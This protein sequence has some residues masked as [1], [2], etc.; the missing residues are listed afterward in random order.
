MT[1]LKE[2]IGIANYSMQS[3]ILY[4]DTEKV[5]VKA[6]LTIYTGE[7]SQSYVGHAEEHRNASN[8]NKTSALENAETSAVGRALAF[9]GWAGDEIASADEV[10]AA[11]NQQ[12]VQPAQQPAQQQNGSGETSG[13]SAYAGS[14]VDFDLYGKA[15]DVD[16]K[17]TYGVLDDIKRKG[18]LNKGLA[19]TGELAEECNL[20]LAQIV[21]QTVPQQAGSNPDDDLPF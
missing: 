18:Q 5:I 2:E 13:P 3:E 8:I 16:K 12:P 17:A 10:A 21:Q 20:R 1:L 9:A 19:A 6:V 14:E 15:K 11:I 7:T 4:H